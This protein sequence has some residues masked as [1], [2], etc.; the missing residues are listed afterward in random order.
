MDEDDIHCHIC[1]DGITRTWECPSCSRVISERDPNIAESGRSAKALL[2][3]SFANWKEFIDSAPKFRQRQDAMNNQ[4]KDLY[5]VANKLGFYDAADY[6][7]N[8]A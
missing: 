8:F 1:N 7:R 6:L 5:Y 2:G 3:D 4:L